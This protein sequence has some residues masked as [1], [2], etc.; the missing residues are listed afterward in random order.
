M[1]I[2]TILTVFNRKQCTMD[3]LHHL[4]AAVDSYNSGKKDAEGVQLTIFMTDDG[5]TDG[6]AHTVREAF[7]DHDIHILQGTG[8]LYWAGGMRLAWQTAIAHATQHDT[9]WDYYLLMNDDTN[10][11]TRVFDELF[12][13]DDWGFS[14]HGKRGLSSGVTC[15]K[16][17]PGHITYGGF[18]LQGLTRGTKRLVMPTGKPQHVDWVHANILLVHQSVVETIGIFHPG[19]VHSGADHDYSST[20]QR[21]GLPVNITSHVCGECPFDHDTE[22]DE[23]VQLMKMT[24][25]E[26]K[27]YV[28]SATHAD[29]D[30]LLLVRR[31]LPLR[32]PMA[33]AVRWLRVYCPSLYYRIT[34]LRGVY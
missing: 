7:A 16:G 4:F 9:A 33:L 22:K 21:H 11:Y 32:Y 1:K 25:R 28:N 27:N 18:V 8:S 26:R 20:A 13:A 17:H 10:V 29:R 30:Y 14:S 6:T 23:I 24:L 19:Y 34:H 5:C 3:C 15:E 2:A 12:E 31:T